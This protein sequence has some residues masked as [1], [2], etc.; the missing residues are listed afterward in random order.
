MIFKIDTCQLNGMVI[1]KP[2]KNIGGGPQGATLGI[3][4]YLSQSNNNADFVSERFKFI[5][6]LTILEIV[7]LLSIGLSSCNVKHQ[8]PS[9][10][11]NSNQFISPDNLDS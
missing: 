4:D 8:V 5:D 10:I 11:I 3:L 1:T 9:D 2:Q 7:D 6:D